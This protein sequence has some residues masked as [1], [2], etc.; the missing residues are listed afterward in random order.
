MLVGKIADNAEI[1]VAIVAMKG[2]RVPRGFFCLERQPL[3]AVVAPDRWPE[4]LGRAEKYEVGLMQK[5]D[6]NLRL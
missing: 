2:F 3:G 1:E 5:A 6:W 4:P